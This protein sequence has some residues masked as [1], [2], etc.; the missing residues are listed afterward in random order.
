MNKKLIGVIA[1]VALAIATAY[2]VYSMTWT[3]ARVHMTAGSA[4]VITVGLYQDCLCTSP[5]TGWDWDG[6]VQ[7]QT[8]E[9]TCYVKNTGTVA[10]YI[11]YDPTYLYFDN[12]QTRFNTHVTV[13]EGPATVCQLQPCTPTPLPEKNPLVCANGFLLN[14]G[15]VIKIDIVLGVD[16]LVSGG[17]WAWDFYIEGCAP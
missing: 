11:T 7:G 13:I 17:T 12:N 6:V 15:K 16:S 10:L 9:V 5:F 8:Y 1:I 3:S 4:S 2:G 14:P